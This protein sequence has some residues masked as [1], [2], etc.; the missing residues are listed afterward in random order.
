M[1]A[2]NTKA[3]KPAAKPAK[4]VGAVAE[5]LKALKALGTMDGKRDDKLKL[6]ATAILEAYPTRESWDAMPKETLLALRAAYASGRLSSADFKVW[7]TPVKGMTDAAKAERLALHKDI[8]TAWNRVLGHAYPKAKTASAEGGKAEEA[9]TEEAKTE[10]N[11]AD[12]WAKVLS[13]MIDQATKAQE[14]KDVQNVNCVGF[15]QALRT[16]RSFVT[17]TSAE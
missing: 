10:G 6:A 8:N 11:K 7:S 2:A 16:A 4:P 9:K 3:A 1:K 14:S 12:L 17:L 15:A 13:A 5:A